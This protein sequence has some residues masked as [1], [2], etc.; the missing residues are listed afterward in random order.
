MSQ[1]RVMT[2][3]VFEEKHPIVGGAL[4][5]VKALRKRCD[6]EKCL[7]GEATTHNDEVSRL[8]RVRDSLGRL[9]LDYYATPPTYPRST[10]PRPPCPT[11][12]RTTSRSTKR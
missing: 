4:F 1:Q 9:Q 5:G 10:P 6:C 2:Q 3:E 12:S 11:P 7:S 8:M